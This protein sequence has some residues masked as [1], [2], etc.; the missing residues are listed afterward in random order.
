MGSR[1][2]RR[3]LWPVSLFLVLSSFWSQPLVLAG[4]DVDF[5]HTD[6][7]IWHGWTRRYHA[8]DGG[9]HFWGF[10]EHGHGYK[11]ATIDHYTFAHRHCID[12]DNRTHVN[13]FAHVNVLGHGSWNDAPA[14]EKK[15]Y[16]DGHGTPTHFME[17]IFS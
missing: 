16:N 4:H 8:F 1:V 13:C 15:F 11:L 5:A 9:F 3:I 7:G 12:I 6:N 2:R 17:A 10:T 14:G